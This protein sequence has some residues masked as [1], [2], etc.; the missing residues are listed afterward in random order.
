MQGWGQDQ[1]AGSGRRDSDAQILAATRRAVLHGPPASEGAPL[2][3]LQEHLAIPRRSSRAATLRVRLDA[4]EAQGL[5]SRSRRRGTARWRLAPPGARHLRRIERAMPVELPEAPQHLAWRH[6]RGAAAQELGRFEDRLDTSLLEARGMLE[7]TAFP[8]ERAPASDDWLRLGRRLLGDCRRL[9]S[10]WYCLQEW[11]EPEDSIP[12]HD[13][14]PTAE[15]APELRALR[16][17]RRNLALWA[18]GD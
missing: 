9:G 13:P 2:W 12:D 16:A 3:A 1:G 11:T 5:L 6:A 17:G 7:A 10:A 4:L 8:P 18:E 15:W 14:P